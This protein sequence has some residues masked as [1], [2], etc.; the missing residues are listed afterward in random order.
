MQSA[1]N[2]EVTIWSERSVK[3]ANFVAQ[4]RRE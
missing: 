3:L 2:E 4:K 1:E